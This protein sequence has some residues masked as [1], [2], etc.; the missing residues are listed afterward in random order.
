MVADDEV[1][2]VEPKSLRFIASPYVKKVLKLRERVL[3]DTQSLALK[4]LEL[5]AM[6]NNFTPDEMAAFGERT[7]A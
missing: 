6:I 7:L 1:V 3:R 2:S 4:E 5:A